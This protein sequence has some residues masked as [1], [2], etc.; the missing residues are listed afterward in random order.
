[1]T[2]LSTIGAKTVLYYE[3]GWGGIGYTTNYKT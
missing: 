1:M 2:R 3:I